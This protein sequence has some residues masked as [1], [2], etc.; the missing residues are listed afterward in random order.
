[1]FKRKYNFWFNYRRIKFIIKEL[2]RDS[3]VMNDILI[4]DKS[5]RK[6]IKNIYGLKK[7][8]Q[9]QLHVIQSRKKIEKDFEQI[10]KLLDEMNN[11][12]LDEK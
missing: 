4:S 2:K 8:K 11:M 5:S 10:Y 9:M 1:M 6:F 12:L 7:V 3:D